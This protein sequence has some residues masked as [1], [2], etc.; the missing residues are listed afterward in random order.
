[1]PSSLNTWTARRTTERGVQCCVCVDDLILR[2]ILAYFTPKGKKES[3][4]F[5]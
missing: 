3:G 4:G 2:V 5:G 1:M